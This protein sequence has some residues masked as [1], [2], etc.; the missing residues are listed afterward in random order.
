MNASDTSKR[1]PKNKP[2]HR[3]LRRGRVSLPN[4]VYLITTT[5][6][7]RQRFFDD[8]N[9]ACAAC[10]CFETTA[11]LGDAR[12]LAW[13]LMP[14]HAHWLIQLGARD[15][16]GDVV[17]RLKSASAR[18]VN[19]ILGRN[20]ALW[21]RAYHDH[22][23]RSDEDLKTVARYIIGNPVRAGLVERVGNYSFWDAVWA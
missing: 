5:T 9:A 23:L 3:A 12:M 16:L 20:G 22:A 15:A 17:A 8:F 13:V 19:R 7:K 10:R 21:A 18:S 14:D 6:D 1:F 4:R 2:G 11:S